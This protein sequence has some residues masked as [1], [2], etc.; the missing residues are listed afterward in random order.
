MRMA[1][2]DTDIRFKVGLSCWN[3]RMMESNVPYRTVSYV[4][5]SR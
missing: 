5:Y 2:T 3:D 4:R 1:D